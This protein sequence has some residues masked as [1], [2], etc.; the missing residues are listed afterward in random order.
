MWSVRGKHVN[1]G[2]SPEKAKET[3]CG[4]LKMGESLSMKGWVCHRLDQQV[5]ANG[6]IYSSVVQPL[7]SKQATRIITP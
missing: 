7:H 4:W 6:A 3:I 1:V 2:R 5:H